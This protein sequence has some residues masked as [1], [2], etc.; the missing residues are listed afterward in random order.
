MV[1]F[2]MAGH[3]IRRLQQHAT[4]VFMEQTQAVGYELTPVQYAALEAIHH[5]PGADQASI[6]A[7]IGYDRATIGGVIQRLEAKGWISR[8]VSDSD[9]R[10]RELSLTTQGK[11]ARA[12][13]TVIVKNLQSDILQPLTE[14]EQSLLT[15]LI[16]RVVAQADSTSKHSTEP[17]A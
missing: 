5:S 13:L 16:Q 7:L 4:Q 14:A 15:T 9:R 6:A 12:A 10:A 11:K 3:L 2:D 8:A 17:R 1:L